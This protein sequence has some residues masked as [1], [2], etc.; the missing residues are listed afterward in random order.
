MTAADL[1]WMVCLDCHPEPRRGCQLCDGT[2]Q[3]R[4]RRPTTTRHGLT[5][6]P[7]DCERGLAWVKALREGYRL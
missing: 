3:Y 6:T 1:V 5:P 7:E 2:G 4:A